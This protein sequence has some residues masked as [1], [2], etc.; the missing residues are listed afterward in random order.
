MSKII[1]TLTVIIFY[2]IYIY[3]ESRLESTS[4]YNLSEE[5]IER[6]REGLKLKSVC[7]GPGNYNKS[8]LLL[9]HQHIRKSKLIIYRFKLG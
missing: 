7:W 6:F 4:E 1:P 8:A 5:A 2:I 3:S 9:L